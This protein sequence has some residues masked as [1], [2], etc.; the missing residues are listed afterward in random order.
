[1][2]YSFLCAHSE[3]Y[4]CPLVLTNRVDADLTYGEKFPP[5]MSGG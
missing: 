5:R 4:N 3:F 1:M 2:A